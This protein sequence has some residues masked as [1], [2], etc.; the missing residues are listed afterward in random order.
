VSYHLPALRDKTHKNLWQD[1][2]PL[3]YEEAQES[4][5]RFEGHVQKI[6]IKLALVTGQG[7]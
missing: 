3:A 5:F 4:N 2:Y 6:A 1:Y 7:Q